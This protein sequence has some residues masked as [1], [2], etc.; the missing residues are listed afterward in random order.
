MRPKVPVMQLQVAGCCEC[1]SM[2]GRKCMLLVGI[3]KMHVMAVVLV[4]HV[5]LSGTARHVS[6]SGVCVMIVQL[7]GACW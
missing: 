5:N 7:V 1:G 4:S 6:F 3:G 2:H